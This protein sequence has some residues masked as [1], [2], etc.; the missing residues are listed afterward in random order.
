MK[1]SGG[2]SLNKKLHMKFTITRLSVLLF[3]MSFMLYANTLYHG[4]VLDDGDLILNNRLVSNGIQSIP[5]LLVTPYRYGTLKSENDLYRPLSLVMFA[6][7]YDISDGKP[8]LSHAI[9]VILFSFCVVLLFIFLNEF[10]N[11]RKIALAF[12]AALIFAFHPIHTEV[13][14]NIKSRD[15][16]LC[17]LFGI[18]ALIT[19][20]YYF[21]KGKFFYLLT[22]TI[23]YF[24]SLFSKETS[25]TLLIIFPLIFIF[26]FNENRRRS[27]F[28]YVAVLLASVV[29]LT[30][31]HKVLSNYDANHTLNVDFID[32]MLVGAPNF[33][34]K[35]A[36]S[37]FILGKY[38]QLLLLPYPL[39]CDY[40]FNTIPFVG[41]NNIYVI[42]SIIVYVGMMIGFIYFL[43]F[44]KNKT[45]AF[46]IFWYFSSI[47]LFSNF[48]FPV[49]VPMA[50]RFL[51]FPSVGYCIIL[52]LLFEK[53]LTNKG[54]IDW[55]SYKTL[56]FIIPVF[57]LLGIIT[58]TRNLDWESNL[59]L[60][61][62]DVNTEP[63]NARLAYYLGTE[64][65]KK[66]ADENDEKEKHNILLKAVIKLN[67]AIVIY[68]SFELA[69]VQLGNAYFNLKEMDS[70]EHYN[71][72]ALK[73][74]NFNPLTHYNLAGVYF[75]KK[76][77]EAAK[78]HCLQTIQIKP[79]W[80]DAYT[81]LAL[82]YIQMNQTDS[83]IFNLRKTIHL[84][85]DKRRAYELLYMVYDNLGMIDSV[86]KYK[87]LSEQKM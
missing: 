56:A 33:T 87:E 39:V 28:V 21:H 60:F 64:L 82:C 48:L 61:G 50:E 18:S 32:N 26:Y 52:A 40:T 78:Q 13:V 86:K 80:A 23:F 8:L 46:S 45:L 31:R 77:Y 54:T 20:I 14:A 55:K 41:F 19:S 9:N 66:A 17:F 24:L 10:F 62:K 11:R 69:F 67:Q 51:F 7:E 4:Y 70:A 43:F 22:T 35:I 83:C 1:K 3:A 75:S 68:P 57:L 2:F 76:N 65:T 5:K 29:Y 63:K 30:I 12:L 36:T 58:F 72:I 44:K 42:T 6:V 53:L 74:N 59:S 84:S 71:L 73:L 79:D 49:G 81:S 34:I 27:L 38:I 16:L 47:S 15:E 25:I 85:H 37:I